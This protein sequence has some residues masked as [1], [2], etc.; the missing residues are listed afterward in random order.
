[1]V[2]AA[3]A[4]R[5]QLMQYLKTRLSGTAA[6]MA[7]VPAALCAALAA[8][9]ADDNA[10]FS[11]STNGAIV[12]VCRSAEWT[13]S[14]KTFSQSFPDVATVRKLVFDM[15][16]LFQFDFVPSEASDLPDG[17]EIASGQMRVRGADALGTGPLVLGGGGNGLYLGKIVARNSGMLEISNKVVFA[18]ADSQVVAPGLAD[19]P[20]IRSLG[21]ANAS[22]RPWLG[23]VSGDSRIT[24]S[25]T[26][27][28]NEALAGIRLSGALKPFELGD[29]TLRVARPSLSPFF[30]YVGTAAD[31]AASR[32]TVSADNLAIEAAA[33]ADVE[34]GLPIDMATATKTTATATPANAS[35]EN[36]ETGWTLTKLSGAGE[37]VGVKENG[38]ASNLD[39]EG[40]TSAGTHYCVMRCLHRLAANSP[41][42]IPD[43]QGE[44]FVAL[45]AATRS[46]YYSYGIEMKV[47]FTSAADGTVYYEKTLPARDDYHNAFTEFEVGPFNLPAGS[48]YLQFETTKPAE[49]ADKWSILAI[50]DIRVFCRRAVQT[51]L[52]KTGAGRVALCGIGASGAV[53]SANAGTLAV[54]ESVLDDVAANVSDGGT[55]ELS[56]GVSGG[57]GGFL[58]SVASGGTLRLTDVSCSNLVANGSFEANAITDNR[59]FDALTPNGW[60][61]EKLAENDGNRD[62]SGV[63]SNGCVV[64]SAHP[65]TTAGDK[66]AYLRQR[67]RLSQTV[68]VPESGIYRF[69]FARARRDYSVSFEG[70]TLKAS[71]GGQEFDSVST[72]PGVFER[73]SHTVELSAGDNTV[74]FE[75]C[76]G[77]DNVG[78]M[79]FIDDVRLSKVSPL[80]ELD[81]VAIDMAAGSTLLL[82]LE[83]EAE[84]T[85]PAFSVGGREIAGHGA[86]ISRAGVA[87]SGKGAV[88]AGKVAATVIHM[89]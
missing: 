77:N 64:S 69:S 19:Y 32:F 45:C 78:P 22:F 88:R 4:W 86:A 29:G 16:D 80:G 5:K 18:H 60:T 44:W 17:I 61:L 13:T 53:F 39:I 82:D 89:R 7:A 49:D 63:Q 48:Y 35:F 73:F 87:V 47:R 9:A 54:S 21:I 15:P 59:G 1:M 52:A 55:L 14:E 74:A 3:S 36:G 62:G 25:L 51:A 2:D 70:F 12:T 23:R 8:G 40:R 31:R 56:T 46:K 50:D 67:T 58:I 11:V 57:T 37:K 28:D 20:V 76:G 26:G 81:N 24:L 79:F 33:G 83:D 10:M 38:G 30:D 85:M 65:W 42:A 68:S 75:T 43:A 34:L 66:T 41:V 71:V 27:S 72:D 6:R 84:V